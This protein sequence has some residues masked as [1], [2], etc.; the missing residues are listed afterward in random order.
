MKKPF[1]QTQKIRFI[2][3]GHISIFS[4]AK[5]IRNGIGDFSSFNLI[6]QRALH[7]L[8]QS[9]NLGLIGSYGTMK[10]QIDRIDEC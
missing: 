7:D 2:I 1:K 3:D 4:T 8:E 9:G 10:I 5:N 6:C